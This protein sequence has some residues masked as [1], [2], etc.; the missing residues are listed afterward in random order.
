MTMSSSV[1]P[2]ADPFRRWENTLRKRKKHDRNGVLT[3]R[4]D[5]IVGPQCNVAPSTVRWKGDGFVSKFQLSCLPG[6]N[7]SDGTHQDIMVL[8]ERCIEERDI[9]VGRRVFCS[10]LKDG[11]ASDPLLRKKL[12]DMLCL[13]GGLQ[14]V[15]E[16]CN[17]LCKEEVSGWDVLISAYFELG[18]NEKVLELY[19]AMKKVPVE[20][21]HDIFVAI[22]RVCAAVEAHDLG[23]EVHIHAVQ[24]GYDMHD[25]IAGVII[26][27]YCRFGLVSDARR[28][29]DKVFERSIMSW[30]ALIEGYCYNGDLQESLQL[31]QRMQR[32][33]FSPSNSVIVTLLRFCSKYKA[34]ESGKQLH[35]SIIEDGVESDLRISNALINMYG[36]CN[37]SEDACV[38]LD[39]AQLH[40]VITWNT[41]LSSYAQHGSFEGA[42][43]TFYAMQQDDLSPNATTYV[44]L[45][46]ACC[47]LEHLEKAKQLHESV[48]NLGLDLNLPVGNSL[49]SMYVKCGSFE[50]VK[51]VFKA[52]PEKDVVSWNIMISGYCEHEH[53]EEAFVALKEMQEVGIQPD[54]ITFLHLLKVCSNLLALDEGKHIHSLIT[55]KGFDIET[56]INNSLI[57]MYGKCG[58]IEDALVVFDKT[59]KTSIVTWNAIMTGHALHSQGQETLQLFLRLEQE[60][61]KPDKVTYFSAI[62]A[63]ATLAAL[64]W[65]K[66]IH[67]AVKQTSFVTDIAVTNALIDMYAKCGSLKDAREAFDQ[68]PK[69][70][71]VTWTVLLSGYAE[72]SDY[73]TAVQLFYGMQ[74]ESIKPDGLAFLSL[75]SAC[76]HKGLVDKGLS[77]LKEMR[78]QYGI[79]ETLEHLDCI[80]D[81]VG[82]GGFF[83]VAEDLLE[84]M[85]FKD[86]IVGWLSLLGSCRLY[87][88]VEVARRCFEYI[89]TLARDHGA[90]YVM[91]ARVYAKAGMHKEAEELEA[92]RIGKEA[93]KKTGQAYIE[94]GN[95]VHRF[96]ADDKSHPQ[97]LTIH[98]KLESLR[99]QAEEQG[100]LNESLS[101]EASPAIKQDLFCRH[102]EKLAITFGLLNTPA[103]APIRVTKNIR[104]CPDCHQA[105]KL[106]TTIE[107][108]E[109]I[110]K[111]VDCIHYFKDG[112]C[113]CEDRDYVN[114]S[115]RNHALTRK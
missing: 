15:N 37:A 32:E 115:S 60:G 13:L 112:A 95:L 85:P 12:I 111:D 61:I 78:D 21:N 4:G 67:A 97:T 86:N 53:G 100:L 19:N 66:R 47:R 106:I 114:R 50:D 16:D 62:K 3:M 83:N 26:E 90:A 80:V 108:R 59:P 73:H 20:P 14:K 45:L 22:F 103:S 31:I 11:L 64:G 109:I 102:S 68:S 51:A 101:L 105:I 30:N 93:W 70:N 23:I 43:N 40:D 107:Q 25:V 29:F 110:V 8:M 42:F 58:S 36:K 63:C 57:D 55:Q 52:L 9:T 44:S 104:V 41:L 7:G 5:S 113:S 24:L 76:S 38:V 98:S 99:R 94:V 84:T 88:N 49:L 72:Q 74:Q 75:L 56:S 71:V 2:S 34:L 39:R 27:M 77:H 54:H 35:A 17:E 18:Q 79:L 96:A 33:G 28:V 10:L 92:A 82:C 91:M 48:L 89:I 69:R 1:C 81:L 46:T 65:G 6:I 87:A